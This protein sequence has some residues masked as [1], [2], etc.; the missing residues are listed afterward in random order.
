MDGNAT[1]WYRTNCFWKRR[2]ST[3]HF[4]QKVI[5][6]IF[7]FFPYFGLYLPFCDRQHGTFLYGRT[8]MNLNFR[9]LNYSAGYTLCVYHRESLI[10]DDAWIVSRHRGLVHINSL[11]EWIIRR[12]FPFTNLL[13]YTIYEPAIRAG[14]NWPA[15]CDSAL[16]V[17]C[18]KSVHE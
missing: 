1:F 13:P 7:D 11:G 17:H 12:P 10:H 3:I 14:N 15:P 18:H 6:N 2:V 16:F 5:F 8:H 4:R 9:C